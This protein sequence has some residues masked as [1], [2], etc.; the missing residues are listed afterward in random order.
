MACSKPPKTYAEQLEIWKSR[1]LIV[2]AEAIALHCL[3]HH[4]YFR[5]SAYRFPLTV[6]GNPD[7]FAPGTTFEILSSL[8]AFDR[9][10]RLLVSAA[11]KQFEISVRARWA[12]VLGHA[13][14]SQAFEHPAVFRDP[15]RHTSAL[16]RLDEELARS[17]E[18]FVGHFRTVHGM[19]R[20]PIW[21]ACEVMSFGLL[22]RF[23]E[24]VLRERDRKEIARTYGLFPNTLKSALEHVHQSRHLG[25]R[26][27]TRAARARTGREGA[28]GSISRC[29][30]A[31]GRRAWRLASHVLRRRTLAGRTVLQLAHSRTG[32][33]TRG[34]VGPRVT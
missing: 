24:N 19:P 23:F 5:L 29:L 28:S 31:A 34:P 12:Y 2:N 16:T 6:A 27:Q 30:G 7:R 1:G 20:P 8:Y 13:H 32:E 26:R 14:G 18:A 3:E 10:L 11:L 21:A 22:S 33:A 9:R 25:R 17:D 15:R 4:N